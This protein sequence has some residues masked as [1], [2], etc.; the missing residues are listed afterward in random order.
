MSH[1]SAASTGTG[2]TVTG[3]LNGTVYYFMVTAVN[4]T[5]NESPF[6]TEVSAEPPGQ[7][8]GWLCPCPR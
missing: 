3:L 5:G 6:S 8:C 1:E 4:A 7:I 2:A